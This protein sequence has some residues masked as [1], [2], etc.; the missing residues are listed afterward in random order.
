M[1]ETKE[2]VLVMVHDHLK[3]MTMIGAKNK[4]ENY[5][6]NQN[7]GAIFMDGLSGIQGPE[8]KS[9]KPCDKVDCW[10]SSWVCFWI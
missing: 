8:T 1:V 7:C 10:H 3:T 2:S 5:P 9:N 4:L 6:K